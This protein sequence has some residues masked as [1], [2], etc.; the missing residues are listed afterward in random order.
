MK[1]SLFTV[2]VVAFLAMLSSCNLPDIQSSPLSPVYALPLLEVDNT[3][4]ELLDIIDTAGYLSV[5]PDGGLTLRF[6]G[7]TE[8]DAPIDFFQLLQVVPIADTFTRAPLISEQLHVRIDSAYF[9]TGTITALINNNLESSPNA[10]PVPFTMFLPEFKLND[11]PF[12]QDFVVPYGNLTVPPVFLPQLTVDISE[13]KLKPSDDS[14]T[15][16][17][18]AINDEGN[19]VKFPGMYLYASNIKAWYVEGYLGKQTQAPFIDTI[20]IDAFQNL[21]SG[22]FS[23]GEPKLILTCENSWGLSAK[24]AVEQARLVNPAGEV[25]YI[26]SSY[27]DPLNPN[28][29]ITIN[30]PNITEVG[31]AK[32]TIFTFDKDNSNIEDIINIKPNKMIYKAT[33]ITNPDNDPNLIV[34]M[35][36]TSYLKTRFDLEIPLIGTVN[37]QVFIDTFVINPDAITLNTPGAIDS[38][39]LG[40]DVGVVD[41][42]IFKIVSL[43]EIPLGASINLHFLD[44][45]GLPLFSLNDE[46]VPL[47][48]AP[49]VDAT[50]VSTEA[51]E[52]IY[53]VTLTGA[54]AQQIFFAQSVALEIKFTTSG[55][56][57]QTV[58]FRANDNLNLKVGVMIH[59][60][61]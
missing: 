11:I 10:T 16:I 46:L 37:N 35:T 53:F 4:G 40:F 26:Q 3:I 32:T 18:D 22:S 23:F 7:E 12:Q 47:V 14:L 17:Y 30:Y 52:N 58:K 34:F 54:D 33:V 39:D 51:A 45:A 24:V 9:K 50:G 36:D 21:P 60:S 5:T 57:A 59:T 8:V 49:A 6:I 20:D 2:L 1:I 29:G 38:L 13:Y 28:A 42:A 55:N 48:A 19:K 31:Q 41:S 27:L 43:N 61:L 15:V 44:N 56:G 25:A